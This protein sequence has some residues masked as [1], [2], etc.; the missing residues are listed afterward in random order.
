MRE[1]QAE[2]LV[3]GD[4]IQLQRGDVVP[5]DARLIQAAGLSVSESALTGESLPVAKTV[6]LLPNVSLPL[7]ERTNMVYRGTVVTG[8]SASAIVVGTGMQTEVGRV[9]FLVARSRPPQT[10]MQRQLDELGRQLVWVTGL[11]SLLLFGIGL[12]RGQNPFAIARSALTLAV[13]AIPEGLPM[14]ATTALAV[15]VERMRHA[16]VQSDVGCRTCKRWPN[17]CGARFGAPDQARRSRKRSQTPA[18]DLLPL[19]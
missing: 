5:A 18:R 10:P 1:L 11:G 6:E 2:E 19:Q 8:G 4:I 3:A 13:A 12:L 14:I 17:D 15:G 9:Q 7:A 16:D